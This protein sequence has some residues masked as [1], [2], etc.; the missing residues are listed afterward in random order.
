MIFCGSTSSSVVAGAVTDGTAG[1]GVTGGAPAT[2]GGFCFARMREM[3]GRNERLVAALPS[4][5]FGRGFFSSI[6]ET[7]SSIG[8]GVGGGVGT[9]LGACSACDVAGSR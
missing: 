6:R 2:A 9:D 3:G 4:V 8:F 5:R 1:A 7:V